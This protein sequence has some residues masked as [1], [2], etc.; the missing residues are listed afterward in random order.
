MKHLVAA[1]ALSLS[2][3]AFATTVSEA[4]KDIETEK[5]VACTF[6]KTS[7]FSKCLGLP[8]SCYYGL[9]YRCDSAS[10]AFGLIIKVKETYRF[11]GQ[12]NQVK[13]RSVK[14]TK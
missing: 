4:V 12:S 1:I 6:M 9:T 10:D 5:N 13:V 8:N 2:L 11:D 7:T 3:S 14:I